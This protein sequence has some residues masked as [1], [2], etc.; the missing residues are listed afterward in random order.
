VSESFFTIGGFDLVKGEIDAKPLI[1]G[2][3]PGMNSGLAVI[4]LDGTL[5]FSKTYRGVPVDLSQFVSLGQP[6]VV[7]TDVPRAPRSAKKLASSLGCPLFI[8]RRFYTSREKTEYLKKRG[9]EGL[10]AHESDALFA[11][12]LALSSQRRKLDRLAHQGDRSL[13]DEAQAISLVFGGKSVKEAL[14]NASQTTAP[15]SQVRAVRRSRASD[16]SRLAFLEARLQM[17]N[18][19]CSKLRNEITLL[20]RELEGQVQRTREIVESPAGEWAKQLE[21]YRKELDEMKIEISKSSYEKDELRR[22]VKEFLEVMTL[23]AFGKLVL[24]PLLSDF[25]SESIEKLGG[26]LRTI[27]TKDMGE[28]G[29]E[30]LQACKR[31]GTGYVVVRKGSLLSA[32][33]PQHGIYTIY[34]DE[35]DGREV[36]GV[37][38]VDPKKLKAAQE[39]SKAKWEEEL[40]TK[41]QAMLRSMLGTK[42]EDFSEG[43]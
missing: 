23:A 12:Q 29:A 25:S 17:E 42:Y 15:P 2:F 24:L 3:D 7:A 1:I 14:S 34:L 37:L 4:S 43:L 19:R 21:L 13:I 32:V 35:L 33:L 41:R 30:A 11:A 22:S 10:G 40:R 9:I 39:S 5:L 8:P 38:A 36:G 31:L 6:V 20:R 26:P 18:E 27:A 28:P 16:S